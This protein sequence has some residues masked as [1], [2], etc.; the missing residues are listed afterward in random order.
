MQDGDEGASSSFGDLQ[1]ELDRLAAELGHSVS[2]DGPDGTLLG[3]SSQVTD[4]D[5]VRINAVLTRRVPADVLAYQRRFGI[6]AATTPVRIPANAELGMAARTCLPIRRGRRAVAYLW[7]L[8][9]AQALDAAAL[10]SIR[11]SGERIRALVQPEHASVV[12]SSL[13]QL[14]ADRPRLDLLDQ[15]VQQEV[16]LPSQ[17]LQFAVIIATT[18]ASAERVPGPATEPLQ[19][20]RSSAV[21]GSAQQRGQLLMLL[22]A[23]G[24]DRNPDTVLGQLLTQRPDPHHVIGHSAPFRAGQTDVSTLAARAIVAAGCA[25][26][27]GALPA[28]TGW[29]GL[30]PYRRLLLTTQPDSRP[31]PLPI[32]DDDRSA[33]ALR[34]TLE[35]FL[36]FGGDAARCISTLGIHR[37]TYYYRLDRLSSHYGVQLADGLSRTDYHLALKTHRLQRARDEF[38]W[39]NRFLARL[40]KHS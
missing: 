24:A 13:K 8:D 7:V 36:D 3:H 1:R 34:R 30:G 15:L 31:E 21:I 5:S 29:D 4:V 22:S 11:T 33:A 17:P 40:A 28:I 20:A 23:P 26:V 27:D 38:G 39:T 25:A 32:P 9:E 6:D 19:G 12:D 10:Q 18:T 14:F 37:T 35:T 16:V 2:L